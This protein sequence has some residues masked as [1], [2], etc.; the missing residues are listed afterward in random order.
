MGKKRQH[1][2]TIRLSVQTSPIVAGRPFTLG[3]AVTDLDGNCASGLLQWSDG[4]SVGWQSLAPTTLTHTY[5]LPG[6]YQIAASVRDTSGMTGAT[7]VSITVQPPTPVVAVVSVAVT[8]SAPAVG[9]T[10]QLVAQATNADHSVQTVTTTAAWASSNPAVATVS[11]GLVTGATNG[12]VVI[13]ATWGGVTGTLALTIAGT[14]PL[15]AGLLGP[16]N[17]TYTG[18]QALPAV[19]VTA[20]P[21]GFTYDYA[22]AFGSSLAHDP[23]ADT[24]LT[25][26]GVPTAG[27]RRRY[28]GEFTRVAP[29]NTIHPASM[30]RGVAVQG[31]TDVTQGTLEATSEVN[32]IIGLSVSGGKIYA[33]GVIP[34]GSAA[35]LRTCFRVNSRTMAGATVEGPY[36]LAASPDSQLHPITNGFTGGPWC[37]IPAAYQASL[38]G[39]VLAVGAS[40]ISISSRLSSGPTAFVLTPTDVN[41]THLAGVVPSTPVLYYPAISPVHTLPMAQ[42]FTDH[43]YGN[44]D[45]GTIWRGWCDVDTYSGAVWLPGTA[46]ILFIGTRGAGVRG[47]GMGVNNPA[48]ALDET[49]TYST[50]TGASTDASGLV[51]TIPNRVWGPVNWLQLTAQAT[52]VFE[53]GTHRG[54]TRIVSGSCINSGT[55]TAQC[56]VVHA[57]TGNLTGQAWKLSAE[58]AMHDPEALGGPGPHA[59]PYTLHVWAYDAADLVAVKA[60]TKLPWAVVPYAEWDLTPP[61]TYNDPYAQPIT[62]PSRLTGVACSGTRM[63]IYVAQYR[64]DGD[65]PVIHTYTVT[66]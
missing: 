22:G 5:A 50:G 1:S 54:C 52:P 11:A 47:Y 56:T 20:D 6:S 48:A 24:F 40:G 12:T 49:L 25:V 7:T 46:S 27:G 14:A 2:P 18:A 53:D 34:Y 39:T 66:P 23:V 51:V 28:V 41:P 33:S 62:Q 31:M 65:F 16:T 57:F 58:V 13:T 45:E 29:I 8:G 10:S 36:Q 3:V 9:S 21:G 44:Q 59:Y 42:G 17:L 55:P 60:G 38:G 61:M 26:G 15:P 37:P 19:G 43:V 30:N 4:L 63:E 32:S 35:E 64:A